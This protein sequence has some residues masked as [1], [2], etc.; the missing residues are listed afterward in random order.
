MKYLEPVGP[1]GKQFS[2]NSRFD[3]DSNVSGAGEAISM[4]TLNAPVTISAI[5]PASLVASIQATVNPQADIDAGT[6]DW[7]DI[8]GLTAIS[9]TLK[10]V[11][12]TGP[13]TAIRPNIGTPQVGTLK[14]CV[15][16]ASYS[17]FGN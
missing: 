11:S 16:M 3:Y 4:G 7:I 9:N 5:G 2:Y 14:V 15:R 12:V 17:V 13:F 1:N 8:T 6:A 10:M